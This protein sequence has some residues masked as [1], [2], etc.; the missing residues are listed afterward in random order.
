MARRRNTQ[1]ENN[2]IIAGLLAFI[3][4]T[5]GLHRFYL[6]DVGGG[7][8]YI[9]LFFITMRFF[10]VT[11]VLGIIEAL[12]LFNMD[13]EEFDKKYNQGKRSSR[14][15]RWRETPGSE[16]RKRRD[17]KREPM[18]TRGY[19]GD[20]NR[21]RNASSRSSGRYVR[22]RPPLPRRNP[23]KS[24]AMDKYREFELEEAI[25]DFNQA[26][27][28]GEKDPEIHFYLAAAYSL[29]EQKD[30]AF[31]HLDL[32]VHYGLKEKE[33]I[34]SFEDLAFV[35]IQDEYDAFKENGYRVPS[36][37]EAPEEPEPN[38]QPADDVLLSQLNKLAELRTKGLISEEEF[39]IEKEKLIEHK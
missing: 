29:T 4:G 10:P 35:R 21:D 34:D 37:K 13:Q 11:M 32:A 28:I 26:L 3:G 14:E 19:R 18:D 22:K 31:R 8:F 17:M 24:S 12:R 2:R 39:L 20:Y 1:R 27:K 36:K 5:F 15:R 9:V 16:Y 38:A 30:K 23:F 6:N 7:I 25:E 33:K